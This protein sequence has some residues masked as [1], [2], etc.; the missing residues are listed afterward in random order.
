MLFDLDVRGGMGGIEAIQEIRREHPSARAI[1][2]TGYID[3]EVLANY[4]DYG[5]SG[6]ITKPFEIE[7][8]VSLVAQLAGLPR[9]L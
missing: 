1:I 9:H 3:D 4:R 7:K 8:L 6:V 5:F 2:C